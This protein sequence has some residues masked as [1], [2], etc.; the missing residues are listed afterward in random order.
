[1]KTC[2]QPCIGSF[3]AIKSLGVFPLSFLKY[4][5]IR[6]PVVARSVDVTSE[7]TRP[8]ES[9]ASGETLGRPVHVNQDK[10]SP[11]EDLLRKDLEVCYCHVLG[12]LVHLKRE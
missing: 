4:I 8:A 7:V 3:V 1:M 11:T 6:K 2:L 9:P 5:S 10:P 12:N